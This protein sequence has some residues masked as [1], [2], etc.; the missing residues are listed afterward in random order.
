MIDRTLKIASQ[1]ERELVMTRTFEAPR[2]L[3]FDAWT[4]P[5]LLQRWLGVR[6]GWT[7][8]VCE[9]DLAVGG[10]YRFVWRRDEG[11]REMTLRGVYREIVR[12]ERIVYSEAFDDPWYPGEGVNTVSF[13]EAAGA[14]TVTAVTL[15]ESRAARDSV[16]ASPMERGVRE[17]YEKLDEVLLSLR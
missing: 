8:P 13:S 3:V 17:G 5:A 7:M 4:K 10:A 11:A 6:G 15:Y 12:P 1:A 2:E 14:T 9:V 16:L